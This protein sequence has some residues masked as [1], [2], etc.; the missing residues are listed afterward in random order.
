MTDDEI[1]ELVSAVAA[2]SSGICTALI[3]VV[4]AM[5]S[6]PGFD[7]PAFVKQ[8]AALQAAY[9]HF[10]WPSPDVKEAFEQTLEQFGSKPLPPI[11]W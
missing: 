5:Q 4:R 7:H 8:L 2:K 3:A 6:Q 1:A 10:E 9:E 11:P